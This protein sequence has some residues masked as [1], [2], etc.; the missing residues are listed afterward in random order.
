MEW[1]AGIIELTAL[2]IIGSKNKY[3]FLLFIIGNIMWSYIAIKIKLYGLLLVTVPAMGLNIRNYIKW[4][5]NE[6]QKKTN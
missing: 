5:G 1:I 2:W 6:N 3:A 4:Q